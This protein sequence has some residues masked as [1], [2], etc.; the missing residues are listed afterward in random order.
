M[1]WKEYDGV[2]LE[3]EDSVATIV[4]NDPANMN[5]VTAA[6]MN[7]LVDALTMC[8]QDDT[9]RVVVLRGAGGNFSAGG[10]VKA[11]KERM[12]KGINTTKEGIR[13]GGEFMMR[14][15]TINKPTIAWI[16]GAA[17]GAG[18]SI[19]LCCDFSIAADDAKMVFAFV[20]IGF[21]PDCGITHML[22]KNI[23]RVRATEL[24][25]SGRRFTGADA[26]EWGM[27]TAAV[28][29]ENLEETVKKY[30]RKYSQ[31]PGVA[32]A[33]I[34]KMIN[35]CTMREL[36]ACMQEEVEA[37]YICSKTDDHRA[38]VEAFCEKR[39]PEFKGR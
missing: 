14:L 31:G 25:M 37:Q 22:T 18:M 30:I 23:G 28:P 24:L 6:T 9:V 34:K 11:M 12:D 3:R 38:A 5:P 35:S 1:L 7:Y 33:Q 27:I 16:E 15:R 21:V 8:E 17:A 19:A 4:L 20:N 36:N 32:Y 26:A 29:K 10:N 39:K 2:L 13:T